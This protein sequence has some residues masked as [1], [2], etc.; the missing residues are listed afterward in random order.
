MAK[1]RLEKREKM[2]A[3][4][5]RARDN[6]SYANSLNASGARFSGRASALGDELLMND[7]RAMSEP[8]WSRLKV[9]ELIAAEMMARHRISGGEASWKPIHARIKAALKRVR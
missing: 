7:A 5:V 2:S 3:L 1:T 6:E 9:E 8:D 4:G